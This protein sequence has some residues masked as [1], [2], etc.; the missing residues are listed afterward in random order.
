[1]G[2]GVFFFLG[3]GGFGVVGLVG[4]FFFFLFFVG[5][6]V[7]GFRG[8]G[9]GYFFVGGGVFFFFLGVFFFSWGV[10]FFGVWLWCGVLVSCG[11]GVWCGFLF[12]CW[13]VG[14][15]GV[16]FFLRCVFFCVFFLLGWGCLGGG[17]FQGVFFG[18]GVV[19]GVWFFVGGG[20]GCFW[21]GGFGFC[22]GGGF[23]F[24][25]WSW[26]PL[27]INRLFPPRWSSASSLFNF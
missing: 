8:V 18:F 4:A 15:V 27:S 5:F 14:G 25:F 22:W 21:G 1:V 23:W 26:L 7:G 13:R 6:L 9:G 12:F 16:G 11:G 20:G 10:C 2:G 24:F 3:G 17:G 19:F